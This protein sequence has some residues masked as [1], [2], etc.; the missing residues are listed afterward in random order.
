MTPVCVWPLFSNTVLSLLSSLLSSFAIK[1]FHSSS[2]KDFI[3]LL[4]NLCGSS[5]NDSAMLKKGA[6]SVQYRIHA[7]DISAWNTIIINFVR[8]FCTSESV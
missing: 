8:L 1:F 3:W 2:S 7:I 4:I 5:I 6:G